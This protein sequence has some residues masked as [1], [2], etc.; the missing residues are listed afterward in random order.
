MTPEN[1]VYW[2]QGFSEIEGETPT[3]E[4]W[5]IIQNHLALVFKKEMPSWTSLSKKSPT[6][7]LINPIGPVIC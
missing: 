4:Q 5:K 3:D 2:L 7:D 6:K 1:F